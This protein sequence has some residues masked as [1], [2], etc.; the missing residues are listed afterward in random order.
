M[1]YLRRT[2]TR[3]KPGSWKKFPNQEKPL[4]IGLVRLVERPE[5]PR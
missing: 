2:I 3:I 5:Q 1:K 4:G